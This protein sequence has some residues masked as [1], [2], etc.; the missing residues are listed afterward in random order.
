LGDSQRREL[1]LCAVVYHGGKGLPPFC[2]LKIK[3][4]I[5]NAIRYINRVGD[6]PIWLDWVLSV[7]EPCV[8]LAITF[9]I[10]YATYIML[11]APDG[12]GLHLF[13]IAWVLTALNDNWK[14]VLILLVP[15]FYRTIRVFLEEVVEFA[16]MKRK[17]K[18]VKDANQGSFDEERT[19]KKAE[20]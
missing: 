8:V 13:R 4:K 6:L 17:Q 3:P 20:N 5:I 2:A 15:L 19:Q 16:G 18:E 14:I 7:I 10:A 9:S 12:R 11:F 1:S